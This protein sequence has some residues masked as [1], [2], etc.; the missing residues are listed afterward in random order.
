MSACVIANPL[1]R[2][3]TGYFEPITP[4]TTTLSN[5]LTVPLDLTESAAWSLQ[6]TAPVSAYM[7]RGSADYAIS[8]SLISTATGNVATT[9]LSGHLAT[10]TK[11][12]TLALARIVVPRGLYN[13]RLALTAL[14]L[15]GE[16]ALG[17]YG[18][19][20]ALAVVAPEAVSGSASV[21]S[22]TFAVDADYQNVATVPLD[23]RGHSW[24]NVS[25]AAPL[26]VYNAN[27]N[28]VTYR[29]SLTDPVTGAV[30][31]ATSHVN[32]NDVID[33][34]AVTPAV[35]VPAVPRGLYTIDVDV[36]SGDTGA[37]VTG[38]SVVTY[39]AVDAGAAGGPCCSGTTLSV[40]AFVE[41]DA[42]TY[43]PTSTL[44]STDVALILAPLWNLY[45]AGTLSL[46]T[47][48]VDV[49][50][51]VQVLDATGTEV[52][53]G[54]EADGSYGDGVTVTSVVPNL[55]RGN[56]TVNL[57]LTYVTDDETITV[58]Q[59]Q[60]SVLAVPVNLAC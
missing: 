5:L 35:V 23:L 55:P 51:T 41:G 39:L 60:L 34:G 1:S 43:T 59:Q 38:S 42:D 4:T 37:G 30:R 33:V 28:T 32:S 46:T 36:L 7:L 9:V 2:V 14:S 20:N 15:S 22:T 54:N 18:E 17:L 25:L 12:S 31:T 8:L 49:G 11:N 19:I 21:T 27:S 6:V 40:G 48:E 24:W 44:N 3:A 52:F 57:L 53:F 58:T 16:N 13:L 56:Y 50:I 29:L 47:S 26:N 10:N 45:V